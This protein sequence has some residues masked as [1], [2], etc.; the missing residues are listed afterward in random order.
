MSAS[1]KL[2]QVFDTKVLATG[3][4]EH[5]KNFDFSKV[6]IYLVAAIPDLLLCPSLMMPLNDR[7]VIDQSEE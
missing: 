6:R 7:R 2:E 3:L 5:V 1:P 4:G